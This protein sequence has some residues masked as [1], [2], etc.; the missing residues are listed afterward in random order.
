L[1]TELRALVSEF[2]LG[3]ALPNRSLHF[4]N[5]KQ[6]FGLLY[7]GRLRYWRRAWLQEIPQRVRPHLLALILAV[8]A[9]Q[10][11]LDLF[12]VVWVQKTLV[13]FSV[14]FQQVPVGVDE[15]LHLS[16]GLAELT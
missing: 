13:V 10:K 11:A 6:V 3:L 1:E 8:N 14:A 5:R 4:R 7:G 9:L 12:Q 15:V 2:Q 16:E